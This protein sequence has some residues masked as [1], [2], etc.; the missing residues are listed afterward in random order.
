MSIEDFIATA[1]EQFAL[2]KGAEK[3]A[4][5]RKL[6]SEFNSLTEME[7]AEVCKRFESRNNS[8]A[9]RASGECRFS[10]STGD[11]T[12]IRLFRSGNPLLEKRELLHIDSRHHIARIMRQSIQPVHW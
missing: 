12:A 9:D 1:D 7:M 3:D 11:V 6:S 8:S 2:P 10:V 4:A 5:R